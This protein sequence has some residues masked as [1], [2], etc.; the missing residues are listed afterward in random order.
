MPDS[1]RLQADEGASVVTPD[2]CPPVPP[3]LP[4]GGCDVETC[5]SDRQCGGLKC[6]YNGCV[7]TCL[8]EVKAAPRESKVI[9]QD[10]EGQIWTQSGSAD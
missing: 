5:E 6:C 3:V 1:E 10:R 7:Y 2:L 8:P 9:S 4:P